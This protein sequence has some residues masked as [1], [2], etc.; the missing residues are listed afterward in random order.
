MAVDLKKTVGCLMLINEWH[1]FIL[2]NHKIRT[3]VSGPIYVALADFQE[4]ILTSIIK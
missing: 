1:S 3:N 4:N 2:A